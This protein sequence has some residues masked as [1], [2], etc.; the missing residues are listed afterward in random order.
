MIQL[1]LK[2]KGYNENGSKGNFLL[3][4]F[5]S[6][7]FLPVL[8]K[9]ELFYE[10]EGEEKFPASEGVGIGEAVKTVED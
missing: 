5:H 9:S 10:C 3:T 8:G 1:S 6:A 7:H 4:H 2:A